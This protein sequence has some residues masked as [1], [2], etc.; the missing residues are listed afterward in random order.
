MSAAGGSDAA[1]GGAGARSGGGGLFATTTGVTESGAIG[2]SA[3]APAPLPSARRRAGG[4]TGQMPLPTNLAAFGRSTRRVSST[5]YRKRARA[6]M[7]PRVAAANTLIL[8]VLPQIEGGPYTDPILR[9]PRAQELLAHQK[10]RVALGA[11]FKGIE[12]P[13][14][15]IHSEQQTA[16]VV[17]GYI[18]QAQQQMVLEVQMRQ[19]QGVQHRFIEAAQL[20][21]EQRQQILWQQHQLQERQPWVSQHAMAPAAAPQ[22]PPQQLQQ[23]S[24]P[25][26]AA[27]PAW[28]RGIH[29]RVPT[30]SYDSR[31]AH[32][33]LVHAPSRS[34]PWPLPPTTDTRFMHSG[35]WR[36][37]SAADS[38]CSAPLVAAAPRV[39]G[40]GSFEEEV[41]IRAQERRA[42][43]LNSR[44]V[45][46][47]ML[48]DEL[49]QERRR[50]M[51]YADAARFPT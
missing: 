19:M 7:D 13:A 10:R 21:L 29:P 28:G 5:A 26:A 15:P 12:G 48:F 51:Q 40:A 47:R 25:Q 33:P 35:S 27:A 14:K 31:S 17:R 43:E 24:H 32:Q 41:F 45:H 3:A 23:R 20:E 22:P 8:K 46:L 11:T 18:A 37:G 42:Q 4:Q 6:A 50:H 49:Q 36:G 39:V 2:T 9:F 30:A 38:F 34:L 44:E 1:L 16:Q